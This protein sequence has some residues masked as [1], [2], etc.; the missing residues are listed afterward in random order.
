MKNRKRTNN[1][2]ITMIALVITII[3]LLVLSGITVASLTGNNG[4]IGKTG[5]AKNNTEDSSA[6]EEI[7]VGVL[8]SYGKKGDIKLDKLNDNLGKIKDLTYNNNPLSQTNKITQLPAVVEL[9]QNLYQIKNDGTVISVKPQAIDSLTKDNYGDYLD[10]GKSIVGTSETSDDWQIIYNDKTAQKVYAILADYL[11]ND[12]GIATA[13]GLDI[14]NGKEY[15]V[16]KSSSRNELVQ[17]FNSSAWKENMLPTSLRSDSKIT[18]KGAIEVAKIF[19]S[20]N[21]KHN[22][23]LILDSYTWRYLYLDLADPSKGIDTLYMPHPDQIYKDCE[24]YWTYNIRASAGM[25]SVFYD[26][27]VKNNAYNKTNLGVRPV[28]ILDYGINVNAEEIG[29]KTVWSIIE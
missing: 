1:K 15:N 18:V 24:G 20:Y 5:E 16:N 6:K 25:W 2:G 14:I 19:D 28:V 11:P 26:G 9:K 27:G 10:L 23:D 12:T 22:T 7:E 29:D 21:E 4:L 13:A 8:Q 3:I 17:G